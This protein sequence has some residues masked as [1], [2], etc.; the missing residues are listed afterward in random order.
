MKQS[1][2]VKRLKPQTA[3]KWR[4]S[5]PKSKKTSVTK[6]GYEKGYDNGWKSG[7]EQGYHEGFD[8]MYA[9]SLND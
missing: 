2:P 8:N 9:S 7:W 4:P 5:P 3:V 1:P 6:D